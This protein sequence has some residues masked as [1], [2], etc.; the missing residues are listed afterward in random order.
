QLDGTGD[1]PAH[2]LI[3]YPIPA[4]ARLLS[5]C[6]VTL[7]ND[8][9][10]AHLSSAVGTPTLALF[11]PTHPAL[12][13]APRGLF[14]EVIQVDESCRPCSLH[15][16]K[17]CYR[18]EQYCCT[19]ITPDEVAERAIRVMTAGLRTERGLFVDRDGTLMVNKH[20]LG[21][22]EQ[23]ELIPGA[24]EAVRTAQAA[25]FT[26]VVISN[27]S[28]VARGILTIEQVEATNRRLVE[29]LA[30][31][32]AE[33]DAIYYCPHHPS[34]G[35]DPNFTR[36]CSCRKPGGGMAEAAAQTLGIDLRRSFVIGDSLDDM[37]LARVIGARG[38]LVRTGH[39]R[40]TEEKL[41]LRDTP[42]GAGTRRQIGVFDSILPAVQYVTA[43]ADSDD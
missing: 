43:K 35:H 18:K 38:L 17:P 29:S 12:G 8:S 36:R 20:Y 39:G 10:M 26:V 31:E 28:G 32:G 27:Q 11:G 42:Q 40:A 7:T 23:V 30:K 13:F 9:G 37:N 21:D 25:G 34:E 1:P 41:H 3:D 15:G 33:P 6:R 19:R 14:D 22:P 4:L 5:R 2:V 24:A 16:E